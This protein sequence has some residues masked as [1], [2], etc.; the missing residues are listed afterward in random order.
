MIHQQPTI[1]KH[2]VVVINKT[3]K[4][5]R[6]ELVEDG[7]VIVSIAKPDH[8][9]LSRSRAIPDLEAYR[10]WELSVMITAKELAEE[11]RPNCKT[12]KPRELIDRQYARAREYKREMRA[13]AK[14]MVTA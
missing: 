11:D 13:K 6:V 9:N 1:Q 5:A 3:R 4:P 10:P 8:T 2:D 14:G 12:R 7:I